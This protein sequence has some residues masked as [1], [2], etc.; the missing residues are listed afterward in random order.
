MIVGCVN[1]KASYS[2]GV[3]AHVYIHIKN[4]IVTGS[5]FPLGCSSI[6]Q[7]GYITINCCWLGGYYGGSCWD[8]GGTCGC[9]RDWCCHWLKWLHR[10]RYWLRRLDR[11][12]GSWLHRRRLGLRRLR[13]FGYTAS[14]KG[15]SHIIEK[16]KNRE[17]SRLLFTKKCGKV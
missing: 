13:R 17:N 4:T 7:G 8:D 2:L 6:K 10:L 1:S 3:L 16:T 14:K 11:L 9:L 12:P 5:G 15:L